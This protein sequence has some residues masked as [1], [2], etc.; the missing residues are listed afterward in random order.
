MKNEFYRN[1]LKNHFFFIGLVTGEISL[2]GVPST[3]IQPMIKY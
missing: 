2:T 1:S 3:L